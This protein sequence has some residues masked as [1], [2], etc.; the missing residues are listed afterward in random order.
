M[1][2]NIDVFME[3]WNWRSLAWWITLAATGA[4]LIVARRR[5]ASLR[6]IGLFAIAATAFLLALASPLAALASRYLFSAHM[7]QHLLLLLIV[8]LCAML[9]WPASSPSGVAERSRGTMAQ[10][11]SRSDGAIPIGW[12]AGVGAMWFWH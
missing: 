8:P 12:A 9:A 1:M 2:T 4:Y 3:L 6:Q 7:A 10:P 5:D 11:R